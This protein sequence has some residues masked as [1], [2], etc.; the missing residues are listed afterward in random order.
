MKFDTQSSIRRVLRIRALTP[1]PGNAVQ[2][3]FTL[4]FQLALTVPLETSVCSKYHG[5]FSYEQSVREMYR[6]VVSRW[7]ISQRFRCFRATRQV[8][9]QGFHVLALILHADRNCNETVNLM[10]PESEMTSTS[11]I[12]LHKRLSGTVVSQPPAV[13]PRSSALGVYV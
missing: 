6:T 5:D 7:R 8:N 12:L 4:H 10:F 13:T 2:G 3:G 1:S 11:E 9:V